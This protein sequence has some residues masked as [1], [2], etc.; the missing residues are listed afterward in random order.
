M[1]R[2]FKPMPRWL[3]HI[4]WNYGEAWPFELP[5]DKH[6]WWVPRWM[7][8]WVMNTTRFDSWI[9]PMWAWQPY[10]WFRRTHANDG[11]GACVYCRKDLR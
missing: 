6:R 2:D 1:T 4:W 3:H 10:C 9:W 7:N 11:H 5:E 8:N